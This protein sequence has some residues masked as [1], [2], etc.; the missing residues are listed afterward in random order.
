MKKLILALSSS[1]LAALLLQAP[2]FAQSLAVVDTNKIFEQSEH[3]KKIIAYFEEAQNAGIKKL[4]ALEAKRKEA[5]SKKDEKAVQNLEQEVQAIAYDL[6]TKLQADQEIL[7]TAVSEKLNQSIEEYR[8]SKKIDVILHSAE[9]AAYNP[10][11]DVTEDIIKEFNKIKFDI[12][13]ELKK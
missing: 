8:K 13:T 3:G 11:I 9:T 2:A 12:Q 10:E 4:E 7:F 5:E 6:Q 1:L